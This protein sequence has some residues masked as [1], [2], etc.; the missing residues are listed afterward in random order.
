MS[1][2]VAIPPAPPAGAP[3]PLVPP[4]AAA[5]FALAAASLWHREVIR[6]FRQPARVIGALG[7]PV[8]FWFVIGSGL[9]ES[10]RPAPGAAGAATDAAGGYLRY[11]FPGS[12]LLSCLFTAIFS[13]IS[14]IEDRT[15]GFLQGV[16]VSPAPRGAV[17][18]GKMLGAAT[19]ATLQGLL[20]ALAAP[21][22]GYTVDPATG[23]RLLGALFLVSFA[24]AGLGSALAWR[25]ATSQGYHAL[26]NLLLMPLWLL[27]GALFPAEGARGWMRVLMAADPL[28]P[29]LSL[30][31]AALGDAPASGIA[32]GTFSLPFSPVVSDIAAVAAF[33]AA[34]Y[35]LSWWSACR[36]K[37][38]S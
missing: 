33:A 36:T 27:S 32:R 28:A 25:C 35:L 29:M 30:L 22:A 23:F 1:A 2:G 26:M 3:A 37:N 12:L 20:F 24:L 5:A 10:F 7:V 13:T 18:A 34:M 11:F 15:G 17:V 21:A 38:P 9:G 16:L 4:G 19:I 8:L 6:F 31:R 14:I